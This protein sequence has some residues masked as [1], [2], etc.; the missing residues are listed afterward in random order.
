MVNIQEAVSLF[1]VEA[2]ATL[3]NP[4]VT[5]EPEDQLRT[6]LVNLFGDMAEL[7]GLKREWIA[8]VGEAP[9]APLK[10]RPD[11]A[12]TLRKTLVGYVELS[13]CVLAFDLATGVRW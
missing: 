2:K 11:Y 6:P 3:A 9:L 8:C 10:T 4:A 7:C 13:Y 12:I 1:G 5:G